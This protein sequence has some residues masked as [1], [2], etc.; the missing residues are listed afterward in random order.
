MILTGC[1]LHHEETGVCFATSTRQPLVL[2]MVDVF[3]ENQ[4]SGLADDAS[5]KLPAG[6]S[7]IVFF[8]MLFAMTTER[9]PARGHRESVWR[10]YHLS[11]STY[12]RTVSLFYTVCLILDIFGGHR[13]GHRIVCSLVLPR[14]S[15][16]FLQTFLSPVSTTYIRARRIPEPWF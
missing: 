9:E 1:D 8:N 6:S 12:F 16:H 3:H 7:P 13:E 10:P 4:G 14:P 11:T 5:G 2:P 15:S